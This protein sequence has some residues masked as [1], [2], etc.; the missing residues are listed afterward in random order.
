MSMQDPIS[1]MLTQIRNGLS[2]A[3]RSV[4]LPASNKKVR[5]ANLLKEE[6]YITDCTTDTV[7]KKPVMTIEL[8][9]QDNKPVIDMI[10][11]VSKPSR[12]VYCGNK[13]IPEVQGGFGVAVISTSEGV[14]SDRAARK[15]GIG[16]EVICAVY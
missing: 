2:A 8:K 12:R 5:I 11:R 14:M 16:G 1:D 3:K 15:R 13:E 10:K 4:T 7:D 9:Y 6:G